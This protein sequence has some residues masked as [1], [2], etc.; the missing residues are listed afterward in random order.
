MEG[1]ENYKTAYAA[2]YARL[3]EQHEATETRLFNDKFVKIFLV[4][5][6]ILL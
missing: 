2:A 4:S 1:T 6:L 3:I 5:I